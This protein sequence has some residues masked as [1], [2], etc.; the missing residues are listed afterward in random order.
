[1]KKHRFMTVAVAAF[2]ALTMAGCGSAPADK[3][4]AEGSATA[5]NKDF[6][7]CLVSDNGGF[8]D[9]SFNQSAHEGLEKAVKELG[10]K[11]KYAQSKGEQDFVPNVNSMVQQKCN[12]IIGV[13]F[14][15][16]D[17]IRDAAEKNPNV[18]FALIDSAIANKDHKPAGLKN[19]KPLLFDT[20]Q[21]AFLAGYAAASQSQTGKLGAYVGM[22]LPTT[23]N[24]VDGFR[25]GMKKYNEDFGK[26]VEL[27]G[28]ESQI[29]GDFSNQAKGKQ[30]T[31]NLLSQGADIIMPVAGP[32]GLGTLAQVKAHGKSSV[33][34]VDSDGYVATDAGAIMLTSVMKQIGQAVYDTVK[35][36]ADGKFK[37]DPYIGTLAN[38]GVAIAPFHDFESKMDQKVI[39]K[40]DELKKG[41]IDGKI[42]FAT[43]DWMSHS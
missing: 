30:I 34:W 19:A 32:V 22:A 9:K 35:E 43:K 6:T 41:I 24:F 36:A 37:A 15:L 1:M 42:K 40:L 18:N 8:Q 12:L 2:V 4:P 16:N 11:A 17:A 20:A 38:G 27:L 5:A 13:G 31:E 33:V 14:L 39:A 3:K 26:K 23:E 25:E 10:I 29:V 21:A 28:G 7:A